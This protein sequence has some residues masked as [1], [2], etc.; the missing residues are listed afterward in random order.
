MSGGARI[1]TS[2]TSSG[3]KT[4]NLATNIGAS[5]RVTRSLR[6]LAL[7]SISASDS[8]T[9]QSVNSTQ[10][11][12]A[13]YTSQQYF[14]GRFSWN[15]N[16]SAGFNNSHATID[17]ES[18]SVQNIA[19]SLGQSLNRSW[20]LGRTSTMNMGFTQ[21]GSAS[22]GTDFD[23]P[24][25]GLGHGISLGWSRSGLSSSTFSSVTLSD[26]RTFSE[27]DTSFQQ[28][29][30]QLTQRQ[31]IS[32]VSA[33]SANVTFQASQQDIATPE[34]ESSPNRPKTLAANVTYTNARTFGI[35]PLR[36]S[37]KLTYNKRF[38]DEQV[39]GSETMESENRFDYRIGL[40][41]TNVTFRIMRTEGGSTSESL[42][43]SITRSF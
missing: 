3:Y 27:T 18:N 24:I 41:T 6:F 29:T 5:Y 23:E 40:L 8:D 20:S 38:E 1:A 11:V 14:V 7:A 33:L 22:K 16:G 10:S 9:V 26:T 35:Y 13:T 15:W 4:N 39:S 37:A 21:N 25:Y 17:E 42:A 19:T 43:F 2:D 32:R 28:L 36:F 30:A 12:S 34:S 31:A